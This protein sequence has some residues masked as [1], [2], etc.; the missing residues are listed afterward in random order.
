MAKH[1]TLRLDRCIGCRACEAACASRFKGEARIRYGSAGPTALLPMACRHCAEPLCA[2]ACPFDVIRIDESRGIVLQATFHCVG[3]R[4]CALAC[5]F[6][7]IDTALLR[8][9]TQKCSLCMDREAGPR[10]AATCPTGALQFAEDGVDKDAVVG[11]GFS[12]RSPHGR[13]G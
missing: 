6:G 11:V 2:A 13:R 9:A 1:L 5:P 3:C 10:C 4:S 12:A 8:G 7:A